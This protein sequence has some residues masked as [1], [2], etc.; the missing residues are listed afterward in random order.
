MS[1]EKD[2]NSVVKNVKEALSKK[3]LRL[4]KKCSTPLLSDY[5]PEQE[6]SPELKSEGMQLYQELI[7][8]L[9]WAVELGRVDILFEASLMSTRTREAIPNDMTT[10]QG[11][12]MSFV[13]L[14]RAIG[15]IERQEGRRLGSSYFA[16]RHQ[17]YGKETPKHSRGKFLWHGA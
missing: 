4:P 3:G 7:G 13:S 15:A 10:P 12:P 14:M 8:V 11:N 17:L 1:A 6:I 5:C 9:R 16:T 2:V